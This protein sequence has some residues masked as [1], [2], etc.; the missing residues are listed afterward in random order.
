MKEKPLF[1]LG[2]KLT[3]L[4]S[5]IKRSKLFVGN[6]NGPMHI[7]AALKI[8]VVTIFGV[9]NALDCSGTWGPWGEG[10]IVICK[11][12]PCPDCHPSDCNTLDC[13]NLVT[14]GDVLEAVDRQ[15]YRRR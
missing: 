2:Y 8:P 1:A 14:V 11:N 15:L 4:V 5:I 6:A 3:C 10:H 9:V 13:M 7:A 12:L